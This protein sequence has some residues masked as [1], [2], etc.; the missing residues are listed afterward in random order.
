MTGI[1]DKLADY[2]NRLFTADCLDILKGMPSKSIDVVMT[3]P[4]WPDTTIKW[5]DGRDLL[6]TWARAAE[7][8]TR[9]SDRVV[10]IVGCDTDPRFF[11]VFPDSI[12]FFRVCWLRRVP[13]PHRGSLLYSADVAYVFGH[14][15]LNGTNRVVPGEKTAV[16]QQDRDDEN[17]HPTRRNLIHMAWLVQHLSR[18]GDLILDPFCGSGTT[19]VAAKLAHRQYCGIDINPEYIEY[20]RKR[21]SAPDIWSEPHTPE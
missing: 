18:P 14:R 3:D 1:T 11:V 20:S 7:Q 6:S 8:M 15:R 13:S 19:C 16:L 17:P 9:I 21:L 10:V 4:P 12:P 5:H 2:R